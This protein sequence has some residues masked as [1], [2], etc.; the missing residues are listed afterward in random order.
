MP[1]IEK[2]HPSKVVIVP[3]PSV[4]NDTSATT[5]A[6][7]G[8]EDALKRA[9]ADDS[10]PSCKELKPESGKIPKIDTSKEKISKTL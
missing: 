5:V 1:K 6:K 10:K 2:E 7:S 9:P 3:R 8:L 4:P